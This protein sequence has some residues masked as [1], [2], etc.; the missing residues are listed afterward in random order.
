MVVLKIKIIPLLL[1]QYK[2]YSY[3]IFIVSIIVKEYKM[4][5]SI[6]LIYVIYGASFCIIKLKHFWKFSS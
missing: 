6:I 1:Q 3:H 5:T 2:E 4:N